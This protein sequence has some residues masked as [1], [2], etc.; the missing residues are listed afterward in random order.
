[1]SLARVD[2]VLDSTMSAH[3]LAL[4]R[5]ALA[6]CA[7]VFGI[8][9][10]AMGLHVLASDTLA[11]PFTSWLPCLPLALLPAFVGAWSILASML[12]VGMWS[13]V[14]SAMLGAM[15]GY[16][17]LVDQQ[18]YSNHQY[19]LTLLLLLLALTD[20]GACWGIDARRVR[21]RAIVRAWPVF[22]IKLQISVV[23]GFAALSKINA[24]Y[25]SG[26]VIKEHFMYAPAWF[27]PPW[28]LS[29]TLPLLAVLSIG[30][31]W[32]LAVA[33]WS[34]RWRW[35]ALV[36]GVGLHGFIVLGGASTPF[37][38]LQ[39]ANF[40]LITMAPYVFFFWPHLPKVPRTPHSAHPQKG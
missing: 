20:S 39:L 4:F 22:L 25:L 28:V 24:V 2:A 33:L 8:E 1:M 21:A 36:C 11:V 12:L 35:L 23:Y 14:A 19:L 31:E 10:W 13:R 16:V 5:M 27:T 3:P 6:L 7:W 15:N 32:F 18:L 37:A 30:M 34:A 29:V 40:A 9:V 17:L 26:V 38:A